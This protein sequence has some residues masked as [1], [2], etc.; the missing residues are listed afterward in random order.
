MASSAYRSTGV[1]V[2]PS[3]V[4]RLPRSMP[5][6]LLTAMDDPTRR[7]MVGR[8]EGSNWIDIAWDKSVGSEFKG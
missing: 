1:E 5:S 3:N 8:F 7:D 4:F 6:S 2:Q